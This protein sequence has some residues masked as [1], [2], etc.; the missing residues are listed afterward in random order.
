[1]D[2]AAQVVDGRTDPLEHASD[3]LGV[4]GS[5]LCEAHITASSRSPKPNRSST[6]A[7]TDGGRD[8]RLGRAAQ[9][10]RRLD[11]PDLEH[12]RSVGAGRAGGDLVDGLDAR[13]APDGDGRDTGQL[14]E[15]DG[16]AAFAC[17]PAPPRRVGRMGTSR[18]WTLARP[19]P[20]SRFAPKSSP[21][22]DHWPSGIA[23]A[24]DGR[25]FLS[26][27]RIDEVKAPINV[28]ELIDGKLVPFPDELVNALDPSDTKHRFVNV[29]GIALGPRNR[30]LALDTGAISFDR[31]DPKAAKLYVIDLDHNA[32]MHGIGF[33]RDVVLRRPTS[34]IW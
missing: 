8:E 3:Q 7:R 22:S 4:A 9:E 30:L 11:G 31:C 28:G 6:P 5:P 32:I 20:T 12:D 24:R 34:T 1:M 25:I 27:P 15:H 17:E 10:D 16:E 19:L 21:S 23:P 18:T 33:P 29:H 13:S 2:A 14:P 26:F